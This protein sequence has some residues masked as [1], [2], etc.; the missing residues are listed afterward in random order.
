MREEK[1]I[2]NNVAKRTR[3]SVFLDSN[4]LLTAVCDENSDSAKL[5][6]LCKEGRMIGIVSQT[7]LCECHHKLKSH[8]E[9]QEKFDELVP[10]LQVVEV[11]DED[12]EKYTT[13][14]ADPNDRH[15]LAG[16]E[17]GCVDYLVTL[18]WKHFLSS[19]A[20]KWL[21]G[22]P[23]PRVFPGVLTSSFYEKQLPR[24]AICITEGTFA[25]GIDPRWNSE[26][27]KNAGRP[28]FILDFPGVFGI[29]YEPTRFQIKMRTEVYESP[30][31]LTLLR[32]ID[33]NDAFLCIVTW[34]AIHGFTC[35]V[36]GKLK[37][38]PRSWKKVP[39]KSRLWIGSDRN[40]SNQINGLIVFHGWSRA[41]TEKEMRRVFEGGYVTLPEKPASL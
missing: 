13:I 41:L 38:I 19:S 10:N 36:D 11:S 17:A 6:Q 37:T 1:G 7:V 23:I 35:M 15:V 24:I 33:D 2:E 30:G 39:T 16:A 32:Y 31:V 18:N 4:V 34:D 3:E 27:V 29:W 25:I 26:T 8:P 9:L 5:L 14:I 40:G 21:T 20:K 22:Y 12:I 28:F